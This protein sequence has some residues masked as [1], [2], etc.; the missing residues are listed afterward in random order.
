MLGVQG[1]IQSLQ[2]LEK[3][4]AGEIVTTDV[5]AVRFVPFTRD[6]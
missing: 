5:L 4:P 2:V 1:A 6:Q 3:T